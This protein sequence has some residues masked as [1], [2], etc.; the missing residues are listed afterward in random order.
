[1][2]NYLNQIVLLKTRKPITNE[3]S[4]EDILASL[5]P[6]NV[7]K[8]GR[9]NVPDRI[10]LI[11]KDKDIE[12]AAKNGNLI[13]LKHFIDNGTDV[14]INSDA[15]LRRSAEYG[16]LFMVK[17]LV[18]RHGAAVSANNDEALQLS[19]RNGHSDV[20]EYLI[21]KGA[22]TTVDDSSSCPNSD[23]LETMNYL[24]AGIL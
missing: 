13:G 8:L 16:H 4:E 10:W 11:K 23:Y 5:D 12:E 7:R 22:K 20:A 24:A 9:D 15:A 1:M 2:D 18:E 19:T 17:Y 3:L 6:D 14:H 21:G